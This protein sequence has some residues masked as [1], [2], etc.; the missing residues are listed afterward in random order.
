[1][2]S[3]VPDFGVLIAKTKNSE[4]APNIWVIDSHPEDINLVDF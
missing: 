2:T 1:M 3:F 4:L